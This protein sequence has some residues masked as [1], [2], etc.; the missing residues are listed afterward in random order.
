MAT[1]IEQQAKGKKDGEIRYLTPLNIETTKT[2]KYCRFK[3][4]GIKYIDYKDPN[5]LMSFVNEQGK[6]L[7]RRLTGTSLKYQRKVAVAVKRARHLALMPY[8]G[9]LLK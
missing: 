9:D 2:K 1:S 3:R 8:V 7:P 6:L 4:S 5:F